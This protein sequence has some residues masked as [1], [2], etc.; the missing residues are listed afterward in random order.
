LIFKI[1]LAIIDYDLEVEV[2]A[3]FI[4]LYFICEKPKLQLG[5]PIIYAP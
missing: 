1:D 3:K 5:G 2:S 4:L